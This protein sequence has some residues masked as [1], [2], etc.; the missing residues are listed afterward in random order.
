MMRGKGLESARRLRYD[1]SIPVGGKQGA[2]RDSWKIEKRD[3][4]K[5]KCGLSPC[6]RN[7]ISCSAAEQRCW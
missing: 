5:A 1:N 2:Q 7:R 3:N 6:V 4:R